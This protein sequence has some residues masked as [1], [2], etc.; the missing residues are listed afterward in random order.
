MERD[1]VYRADN[2]SNVLRAYGVEFTLK[3]PLPKLW[4]VVTIVWFE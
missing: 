4:K 3:S 2:T 1:M